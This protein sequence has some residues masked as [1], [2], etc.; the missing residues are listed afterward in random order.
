MSTQ[1][2]L[3]HGRVSDLPCVRCGHPSFQLIETPPEAPVPALCPPHPPAGPAKQALWFQ[4]W[5]PGPDIMS[6]FMVRV[7]P[8]E[9]AVP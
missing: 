5:G 8:V 4:N 3:G 1:P 9:F 7:Q 6:T 2:A